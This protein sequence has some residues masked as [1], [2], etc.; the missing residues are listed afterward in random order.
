MKRAACL[1]TFCS[2]GLVSSTAWAHPGHPHSV[3]DGFGAG[4]AHPWLGI[5]HLL[6][7]VAV[8]LLSVQ[9]GGRAVWILPASFLGMMML[10]G[11][12]GWTSGELAWIEGGI[13]SSVVALGAALAIGRKYPLAASAVVIGAFGLLHGLAHGAEMPGLAAPALYAA[14]FVSA[15]SLL[16]FA[17]IAAGSLAVS[18][19]PLAAGLRVCGAAM[20]CVGVLLLIGAI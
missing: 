16:H 9:R 5:D 2:V 15:T 7:M 12:L 20:S 1:L 11:A 6:A 19:R 4:F 14:G 18:R 17:G 13:A 10:G 8:G 3:A